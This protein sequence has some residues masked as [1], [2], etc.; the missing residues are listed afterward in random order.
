MV[1]SCH[2][3]LGG[4]VTGLGAGWMW[5]GVVAVCCLQDRLHHSSE[6]QNDSRASPVSGVHLNGK[7]HVHI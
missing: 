6:S 1:N 2:V 5:I 3:L 7:A 4:S